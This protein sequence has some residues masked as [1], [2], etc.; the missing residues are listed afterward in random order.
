MLLPLKEE[1]AAMRQDRQAASRSLKRLEKGSLLDLLYR[2][3]TLPAPC[4]DPGDFR[5]R[6]VIYRTVSC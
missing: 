5:V 3:R 2:Q 1:K 4:S 6:H